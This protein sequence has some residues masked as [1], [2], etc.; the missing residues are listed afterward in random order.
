M[1]KG[2]DL[3]IA[4]DTRSAMSAISRGVIDPLEDVADLLD[5][6]GRDGITAGRNLER[7]MRDAQ[8][9]TRDAKD[10]IREIRDQ[11]N[12]AGRAG[13]DAGDDIKRGMQRGEQAAEAFKDEAKQNFAET[14]SSFDGSMDSIADMAQSTLGGLATSIPVAGVALAGLGAIGGTVYRAWADNAA[15]IEER[16]QEMYDDMLESGQEYLSADFINTALAE[17]GKDKDRM[18]ELVE[19]QK[20]LGV[21]IEDVMIAEITAGDKRNELLELANEKRLRA[22]ELDLENAQ[23]AADG[24]TAYEGTDATLERIVNRYLDLNGQQEDAFGRVT[25]TKNAQ[26]EYAN[27]VDNANK[28]LQTT[29]D[30]LRGLP[31]PAPVKLT[32]DDSEVRN[33]RPP[34]LKGSVQYKPSILESYWQ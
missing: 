33:W 5:D 1:T 34:M 27:S 22:Q 28:K 24:L 25:A 7:G 11:L 26:D 19:I 3:A 32:V 18:R 16:I 12:R 8:R 13:K 30:Q 20:E 4:A 29:A 21:E 17:L 15:K 14:A 10:E 23:A 9:R 6:V 2:I 31:Q